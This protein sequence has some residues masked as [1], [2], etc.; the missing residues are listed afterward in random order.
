MKHLRLILL[1]SLIAASATAQ[2]LSIVVIANDGANTTTNVMA[3]P[4]IRVQGLL[5]QWADDCKAKTNAAPPAAALTFGQFIVQEIRD[6]GQGAQDIGVK[7]DMLTWGITNAPAKL[8]AAWPNLTA[9]QKT[10]A[11]NYVKQIGE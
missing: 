3:V 11:A 8:V 10:N 1:T 5:S 2:S 7:A 4:A 9:T 6:K